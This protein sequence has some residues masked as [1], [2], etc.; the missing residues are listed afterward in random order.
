M[1]ISVPSRSGGFLNSLRSHTA[2]YRAALGFGT[3]GFGLTISRTTGVIGRR[4]VDDVLS[5]SLDHREP[6]GK[7]FGAELLQRDS[8][9]GQNINPI[10]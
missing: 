6:F 7:L 4:P 2:D 9:V 3:L 8:Q 1:Q 10:S 5:I